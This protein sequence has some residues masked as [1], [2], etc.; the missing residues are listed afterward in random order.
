MT[1]HIPPHVLSPTV[2]VNI[3]YLIDDGQCD[4]MVRALR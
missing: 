1:S 2:Q 4:Q 3:T